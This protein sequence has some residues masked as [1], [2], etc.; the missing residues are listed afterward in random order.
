MNAQQIKAEQ[1]EIIARASIGRLSNERLAETWM[2]TNGQP[3]ERKVTILRGWLLDE[4]ET[5]MERAT[6]VWGDLFPNEMQRDR[7]DEWLTADSAPGNDFISPLP[8]LS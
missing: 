4:I 2:L 6:S 7:F 1:S 5:R 3:A 8:Y